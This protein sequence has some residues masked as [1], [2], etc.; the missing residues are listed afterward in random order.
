MLL[1]EG[2]PPHLHVHPH[3]ELRV[4]QFQAMCQAPLHPPP[5]CR[6][7]T[8]ASH[9]WGTELFTQAGQAL[10]PCQFIVV[11]MHHKLDVK[12][13]AQCLTPAAAAA[14]RCAGS[15]T[16]R[17]QNMPA[18]ATHNKNC[19]D[20]CGSMQA[21]QCCCS[22]CSMHAC[23]AVAPRPNRQNQRHSRAAKPCSSLSTA[24]QKDLCHT[25]GVTLTFG[26]AMQH[27]PE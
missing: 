22:T 2:A 16:C 19:Y 11:C 10:G 15:E 12:V 7:A 13:L 5:A 25:P 1:T 17:R 21:N 24:H 26:N 18:A 9:W 3:H 14:A 4:V 23:R 8:G 27:G 6:T 20:S